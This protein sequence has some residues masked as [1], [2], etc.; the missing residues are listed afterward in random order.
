[1]GKINTNAGSGKIILKN[2]S[3]SIDYDGP[4]LILNPKFNQENYYPYDGLDGNY[5]AIGSDGS[6]IM[7]SYMHNSPLR[8][9]PGTNNTLFR[10][11]FHK[12]NSSYDLLP[13]NAPLQNRTMKIF[14]VGRKFANVNTNDNLIRTISNS[15]NI[16]F[17]TDLTSWTKYSAEALTAANVPIA[18]PSRNVTTVNFGCYVR[19][20]KNNQLRPKNFGGIFIN[21]R[22]SNFRSYVNYIAICGNEVLDLLGNDNPYTVFRTDW[23][24]NATCQWV[25]PNNSKVKVKKL[26][27]VYQ[28]DT[29]D[30]WKLLTGSVAIPTFSTSDNDNADGRA[31]FVSLHMYLA[32]SFVYL[33]NNDEVEVGPMFFYNP[34]LYF[35]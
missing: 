13:Y 7:R 29:Y 11:Q 31:E 4:N 1:M 34:Y 23:S 25:G 19:I 20:D 3:D 22:K 16:G 35:S 18:V 6:V 33:N 17:D 21:F 9:D 8:Y 12:I 5:N 15:Y 32:E 26:S 10:K 27:Q 28:D 24:S 2:F 14:P 30:N